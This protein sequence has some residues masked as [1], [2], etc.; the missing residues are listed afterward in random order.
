MHFGPDGYLYISTGDGGGQND[1]RGNGQVIDRDFFCAILR[2]D[3]DKRPGNFEPNPHASVPLDGGLA[4]YAIP[5][6]NPFVIDQPTLSYNG[7]TLAANT[8]RTEFFANGLRNPWKFSFDS[9][10]GDLWCGDVGQNA[11]EEIN[12]ITNG[13]NYGWAYREGT[14]DGPR[15]GEQPVGFNPTPPLYEYSLGNGELQGFSVTGGLVYHGTNVQSLTGDYIFG[16][17]VS[18]NIWALGRSGSTVNVT[19]VTGEAGI[20]AFGTDPSNGDLL[21]VDYGGSRILRLVNSSTDTGDFPTLLSETGLFADLSDLSPAPGLLPYEPN[22]AFWS[23]YAIKRRWFMIPD[24][25][26]QVTWQA[27]DAWGY[28][29]GMIWVKHFDLEGERGNTN[30][31]HRIETRLLVKNE[32]GAYGVSYRWNTNQTDAV[33]V[34]DA[35]ITFATNIVVNGSNYTQQVRIPSRAE[36]LAC[37]TPQAGH[38]LSFNTRQLNR[39]SDLHGFTGNQIDLLGDGGYLINPPDNPAELP[40][41]VRPDETNFSIEARVRSYLDTNCA[42]CHRSGGTATESWDARAQ[43]SLAETGVLNGTATNNGGDPAN[44]LV[45][46]GDLQRSIILNRVAATNGFTRMPQLGSHELDHQSIALLT[47]WIEQV[48]PNHQT[49]SEWRQLHFSSTS[50]PAGLPEADPDGDQRSNREEF[51]T[52]TNPNDPNSY[53]QPVLILQAPSVTMQANVPDNRSLVIEQST[54]LLHWSRWNAT[55]NHGLPLSGGTTTFE[56]PDVFPRQFFRLQIR[57]H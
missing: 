4:R 3:V 22:L 46:P 48:L 26:N 27:E 15:V 43:L 53:F 38:A 19:R 25:T 11:R 52:A 49:Y 42:N 16:D 41:H 1:S 35:G 18:G 13:G 5:A 44:R 21:A 45:V 2:I 40:R 33:L 31:L 10:T 9:V 55:N 34:G 6:D 28:P 7:N 29:D 39:A 37:H 57:E 47:E 50:S 56:G 23:D 54:N 14:L 17:Y 51:L 30:T 32:T 12:I 24:A 20:T 8:V 36:C